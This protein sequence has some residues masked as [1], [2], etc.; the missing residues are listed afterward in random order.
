MNACI[1]TSN[2]YQ[3][4]KNVD[5]ANLLI[6]FIITDEQQ[7]IWQYYTRKKSLK[8]FP[9]QNSYYCY[10]KKKRFTLKFIKSKY[11]SINKNGLFLN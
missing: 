2:K 1:Q 4:F 6:M 3:L 7:K 5:F 9:L 8:I 10:L 11:T